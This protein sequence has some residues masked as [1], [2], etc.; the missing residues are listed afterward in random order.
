MRQ[1]YVAIAGAAYKTESNRTP[2]L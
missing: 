1:T 2:Q